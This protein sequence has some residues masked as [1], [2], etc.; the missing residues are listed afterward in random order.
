MLYC[1]N[2]VWAEGAGSRPALTNLTYYAK[3]YAVVVGIGRYP[4][5]KWSD[6]GYARKDAEGMA[7]I[8]R[9]QGFDVTTLY[10]RQATR[11]AVISVF[12]DYLAPRLKKNDRVLVF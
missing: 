5:S 6:L 9:K 8:L 3:S 11:Q 1:G 10:D 7:E 4:S 2:S 12:E